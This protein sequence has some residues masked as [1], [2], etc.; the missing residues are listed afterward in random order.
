[1]NSVTLTVDLATSGTTFLFLLISFFLGLVVTIACY[2]LGF[3]GEVGIGLI[4]VLAGGRPS[5]HRRAAPSRL[6]VFLR[7]IIY[8]FGGIGALVLA[9]N[10][11]AVWSYLLAICSAFCFGVT[12]VKLF[13]PS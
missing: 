8:F 12:V 13:K 5:S 2:A 6:P 11:M 3:I 4:E 10:G 9:A 1:M 7:S